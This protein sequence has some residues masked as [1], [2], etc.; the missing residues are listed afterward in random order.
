MIS[1]DRSP[2]VPWILIL[3]IAFVAYWQRFKK[4]VLLYLQKG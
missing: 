3:W 1:G 4:G 2:S